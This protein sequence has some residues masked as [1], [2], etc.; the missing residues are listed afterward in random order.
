[1]KDFGSRDDKI[2]EFYKQLSLICD[3][4]NEINESIKYIT[5]AFSLNLQL[6]GREN[7]NS[8]QFLK[9]KASYYQKL[10]NSQKALEIYIECFNIWNK[11]KIENEISLLNVINNII[12]LYSKLNINKESLSWILKKI[13]ML[14]KIEKTEDLDLAKTLDHAGDVYLNLYDTK[15]SLEV[16][17]KAKTIFLKKNLLEAASVIDKKIGIIVEFKNNNN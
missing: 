13:E 7:Y 15:H 2:I 5:E 1:M 9:I 10:N 4:L 14:K 12:F 16:Y 17:N 8:G 6:H 11:I 3:S